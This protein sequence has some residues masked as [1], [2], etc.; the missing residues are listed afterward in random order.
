MS[1]GRLIG[2]GLVVALAAACAGPTAEMKK[3]AAARSAM[4]IT[5]LQQKNLPA[6]MRELSRAADLDPDNPEIDMALGLAYRARG[7]FG[8]AEDFFRRALRKKPNY[9]EAH[10]NLGVLLSDLGRS[11]EALREY[12]AAA[13]NVLYATPEIAYYNM[14]EEYRRQG[15]ADRAE[16]MYRRALALNERYAPA[17]RGLAAALEAQGRASEAVAA[18]EKCVQA[19]PAYAPAWLDL[20]VAYARAGKREEALRAFRGVLANS[21]DA[22]LRGAAA[23][24]IQALGAA[25]R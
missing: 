8:K 21:D 17:Y 20:G 14:G 24:R 19:T 11:A 25:P 10:N 13:A 5:Y 7:D 1:G 9:S 4:G 23:E 18:L 22:A 2:I 3:E 12:E 16:L 6:A 15:K